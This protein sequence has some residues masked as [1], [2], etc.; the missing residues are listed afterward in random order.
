MPCINLSFVITAPAR[1]K[2][3][4]PTTT[5]ALAMMQNRDM[6]PKTP[7]PVLPVIV[8]CRWY[9]TGGIDEGK[10]AWEVVGSSPIY[11]VHVG[12]EWVIMYMFVD[13]DKE[14]VSYV[15]FVCLRVISPSC[16]HLLENTAACIRRMCREDP[17][18]RVRSVV[19]A[20]DVVWPT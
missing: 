9:E 2:T 3:R 7:A 13:V 6:K 20:R 5:P 8:V 10:C 12:R 19:A 17:S 15:C 1:C 14:R 18:D 4:H 16:G 11:V